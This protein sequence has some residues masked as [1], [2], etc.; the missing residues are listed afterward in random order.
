M[1]LFN[2]KALAV[3]VGAMLLSPMAMA[4]GAVGMEDVTK[5]WVCTSDGAI[6]GKTQC[7]QWTRKGFGSAQ[8]GMSGMSGMG[9]MSGMSGMG[10]MSG[11]SGMGG[12]D[13]M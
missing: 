6:D 11:M 2:R 7:T 12:M 8:T 10:G 13:G 3:A 1:K 9:G 5:Q 4:E